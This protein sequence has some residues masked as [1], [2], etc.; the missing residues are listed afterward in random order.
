VSIREI[1]VAWPGY[2]ERLR[3]GIRDL[4]AE[5][6]AVRPAPEHMTVWQLAAHVA[7]A[8]VYWLCGVL[9]EPGAADTFLPDPLGD[10]WE[11]DESHPRTAEELEWALSSSFAVVERCL[12]RWTVDMLGERF[13]RRG[14]T[15][16][17][18][19]SRAQLLTRLMTHDAFHAGEIS[20]TRG[21]LGL[22]G[23]EL[24]RADAVDPD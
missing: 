17:Q 21:S 18:W 13:P 14:A 8:R 16:M 5:Q 22:P 20:Q 19:H 24:W 15:G 9:G 11:D 4:T 6:L 7:G 2:D 1:F 3:E 23:L 12:D 10:G